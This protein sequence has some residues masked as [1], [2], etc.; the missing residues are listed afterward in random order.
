MSAARFIQS[1]EI[2]QHVTILHGDANLG[3]SRFE[4]EVLV[5]RWFCGGMHAMLGNFVD[6]AQRLFL[7]KPKKLI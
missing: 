5:G 7:M 3:L 6:A 2:D 1:K 4:L